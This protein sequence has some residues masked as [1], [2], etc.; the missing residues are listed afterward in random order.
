MHSQTVETLIAKLPEILT[1]A[2]LVVTAVGTIVLGVINYRRTGTSISQSQ[3]NE[4][5]IDNLH[6]AV[7]G[8]T[9]E[10]LKTTKAL[11]HAEGVQEQQDR[12]A[13]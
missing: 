5:K 9:K 7:N 3:T 11:G 10:L 1:A 12:E 13:K 6:E 2:G 8:H 4:G